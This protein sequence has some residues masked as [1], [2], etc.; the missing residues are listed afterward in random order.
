MSEE[1]GKT[2]KPALVSALEQA[3]AARDEWEAQA[4]LKNWD[5][6]PKSSDMKQESGGLFRQM[7]FGNLMGRR[8][9]DQNDREK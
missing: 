7:F 4:I 1:D 5:E 8:R 6:M 9:G 3:V 2:K